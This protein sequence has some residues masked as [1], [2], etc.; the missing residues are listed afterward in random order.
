M[1]STRKPILLSAEQGAEAS[2]VLARAFH[3]DP[4]M[5]FI[6]PDDNIRAR[7][8]PWLLSTAVRYGLLYGRIYTTAKLEGV[9]IWF[10]PRYAKVTLWRM[11][12]TGMLVAPAK[13]GLRAFGRFMNIMGYIENVQN[14]EM[15]GPHWYLAFIGVEPSHQGRGIGSSLLE[16]VEREA[17]HNGVPCYLDT[18]NENNLP[19]YERHDFKVTHEGY[20]PKGGPKVWSMLREPDS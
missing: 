2:R 8:L 13:L 4:A 6:L 16:P 1:N 19:L 18:M 9:A 14:T 11:A 15:E 10:D 20:V 7:R 12:R 5:K 3:E 17:S